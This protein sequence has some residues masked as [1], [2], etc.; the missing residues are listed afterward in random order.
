MR[1]AFQQRDLTM[2]E[3]AA[4]ILVAAISTTFLTD[5]AGSAIRMIPRRRASVHVKR[6]DEAHAH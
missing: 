3:L 6:D 4:V 2:F 5:L 1:L